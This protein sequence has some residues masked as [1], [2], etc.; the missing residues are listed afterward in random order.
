MARYLYKCENE[1]CQNIFPVEFPFAKNQTLVYCDLCNSPARRYISKM[2]PF[3]YNASGFV[4][5][6]LG[7]RGI[8]RSAGELDTYV[9]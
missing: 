7:N 1:G 8:P 2:V 4:G 9:S 6:K 3:I 5:N